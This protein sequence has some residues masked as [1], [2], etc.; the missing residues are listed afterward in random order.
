MP[1]KDEGLFEEGSLLRKMGQ[2]SVGLLGGGRALLLQ[3]AHPLIAAGIADHSRF[4]AEPLQR[5]QRTLDMMH[6]LIYGDKLQ[7]KAALRQFHAA[8][9]YVRGKMSHAAGCFPAGASYNAHDPALKLWVLATLIDSQLLVYERFVSPLSPAERACFYQESK[10]LALWLGIPKTLLPPNLEAFQHYMETM[11]ASDTLAVTDA[12]R[13]IAQTLLDPPVWIVPRLCAHLVRF[14]TAGLL[15]EPL[16]RAYGLGW[17][18]H[19]EVVLSIL[20]RAS[21]RLLPHLSAALRRMPEP[22]GSG[23]VAWALNGGR[24]KEGG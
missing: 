14:V 19:W 18:A 12:A 17:N 5:L 23:F 10:A 1:T 2:E 13:T 7:A 24:Q 4:Q 21:R 15:P 9:V 11:L 6:A 8:H 20:A 3:L 22:G 16:R